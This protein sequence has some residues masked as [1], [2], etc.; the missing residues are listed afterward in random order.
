MAVELSRLYK[1]I[2]P[3]HDVKLLTHGCFEK[4]VQRALKHTVFF[5]DKGILFVLSADYTCECLKEQF[6]VWNEKYKK[7]QIGIG[8]REKSVKKIYRSYKNA[9]V[10]LGIARKLQW[11]GPCCYDEMGLYQILSNVKEPQVVY[12]EFIKETLGILYEY[13]QKHGTDYID[14]LKM[15]FENDC[16]ITQTANATYYHQNTL[17]YKVKAIKEILGYD[18]MSNENRV[19][20]MISLYLLQLGENFWGN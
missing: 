11:E 20:I 10:A 19:K 16:S 4:E 8:T 3:E 18:I 15:F 1:E 5:E 9:I 14:I 17:K 7:I 13:D 6:S 12:P 2:M